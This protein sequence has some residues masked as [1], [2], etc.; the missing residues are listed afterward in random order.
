MRQQ[1]AHAPCA[2]PRSHA[3]AH[4]ACRA[5]RS[6]LYRA[7]LAPG[8]LRRPAVRPLAALDPIAAEIIDRDDRVGDPLRPPVLIAEHRHGMNGYHREPVALIEHIERR[9]HL[10]R[11]NSP[12]AW[13]EPCRD[14]CATAPSGCPERRARDATVHAPPVGRLTRHPV[15]ADPYQRGAVPSLHPP[16]R[17]SEAHAATC[18]GR[19]LIR[20]G[21]PRAQSRC[22]SGSRARIIDAGRARLQLSQAGKSERRP[23][24][25]FR[26]RS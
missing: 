14:R 1:L 16:R 17:G 22:R 11:S 18:D 9:R 13:T 25:R 10:L 6:V 19:V 12:A 15:G 23:P 8:C 7:A 20:N 3:A 26:A 5:I 21:R 4:R 2:S 24:L